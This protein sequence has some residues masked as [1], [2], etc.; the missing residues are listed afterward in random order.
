M[1]IRTE[2]QTNGIGLSRRTAESSAVTSTPACKISRRLSGWLSKIVTWR[3]VVPSITIGIGRET[4][5]NILFRAEFVAAG[6]R[7]SLGTRT[8]CGLLFLVRGDIARRREPSLERG[9]IIVAR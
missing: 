7:P 9:A 8:H 5:A 6:M 2:P 1:A 3:I 4:I